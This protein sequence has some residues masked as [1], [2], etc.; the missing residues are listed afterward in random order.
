MPRLYQADS[1]GYVIDHQA[2]T[3]NF[4]HAVLAIRTE[5]ITNA[6]KV[7]S[8]SYFHSW[9]FSHYI[10]KKLLLSHL[11]QLLDESLLVICG[12]KV[13]ND[14]FDDKLPN[15]PFT[16]DYIKVKTISSAPSYGLESQPVANGDHPAGSEQWCE[17]I[18]KQL[19]STLFHTSPMVS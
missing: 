1:N 13:T 3:R 6:I 14:L 15:S 9:F 8:I 16:Y 19:S 5:V 18:E 2:P 17:A 4:G 12:F 7:R 11:W 10:F